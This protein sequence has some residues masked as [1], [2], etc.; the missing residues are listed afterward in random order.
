MARIA[1]TQHAI[2]RFNERFVV[3][4]GIAPY[5][6]NDARMALERATTGAVLLKERT[7]AGHEQFWA[8]VDIGLGA[9]YTI[10][11]VVLVV[12]HDVGGDCY[13]CVTV[14]EHVERNHHKYAREVAAAQEEDAQR[15]AT[16][17][18]IITA[19]ER[20]LADGKD[21]TAD[22]R[23]VLNTNT[24]AELV[25]MVGGLRRRLCERSN[26]LDAARARLR[27]LHGEIPEPK[28]KARTE[29][30]QQQALADQRR[31]HQEQVT[32]M[33]R[34]IDDKNR[35]TT[36]VVRYGKALLAA[37]RAGHAAVDECDRVRV[38]LDNVAMHE[39][40]RVEQRHAGVPENA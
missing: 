7:A 17:V 21:L 22:E 4:A 20:W 40:A 6:T 37:R 18:D 26:E 23:A 35:I 33:Q 34:T 11:D 16:T 1:F 38:E 2:E 5:K 3:P 19:L 25:N 9:Q 29:H 27:A 12:K 31:A 8:R 14:H 39:A 36:V 30:A 13:V 28:R 32:R 10:A 15:S 24:R